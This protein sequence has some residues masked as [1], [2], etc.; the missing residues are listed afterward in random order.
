V[1]LGAETLVLA[2][3]PGRRDPLYPIKVAGRVAEMIPRIKIALPTA[4]PNRT[5]FT[6]LAGH[7]AKLPP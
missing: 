1:W 5:G 7:I 4:Y 2:R 3:S 6:I